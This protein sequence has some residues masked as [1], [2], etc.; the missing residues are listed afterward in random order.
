MPHHGAMSLCAVAVAEDAMMIEEK[1]HPQL[2]GRQAE[3]KQ[4]VTNMDVT[5]HDKNI[6]LLFAYFL[7][8]SRP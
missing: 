2:S 4:C 7:H 3:G 8:V 1:H 6:I 5:S